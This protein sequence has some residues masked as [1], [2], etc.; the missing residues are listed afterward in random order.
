M[1]TIPW[2]AYAG[3]A[4]YWPFFYLLPGAFV[5]FWIIPLLLCLPWELKH[6]KQDFANLKNKLKQKKEDK[7]Q[8]KVLN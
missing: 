6:I 3:Q 7:K 4:K 8:K 1:K 2:G 5:Y